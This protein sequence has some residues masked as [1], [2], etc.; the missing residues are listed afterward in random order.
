M[1]ITYIVAMT[2]QGLEAFVFGSPHAVIAQKKPP[3]W[4][5]TATTKENAVLRAIKLA[6]H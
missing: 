6:A 3:F 5:V 2:R 4:I 1:K